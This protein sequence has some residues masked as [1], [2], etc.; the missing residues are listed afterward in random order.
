MPSNKTKKPKEQS[1]PEA[2]TSFQEQTNLFKTKFKERAQVG[3]DIIT[4][5]YNRQIS[6]LFITNLALQST[7]IQLRK[8]LEIATSMMNNTQKKQFS[9]KWEKAKTKLNDSLI[10]PNNS[11][12]Q[13]AT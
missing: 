2:L 10:K 5:E 3:M 13:H 12:K 6:N 1:A 7:N 9:R 4:D 11:I 8:Q